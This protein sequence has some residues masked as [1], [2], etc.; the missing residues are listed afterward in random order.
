M[1]TAVKKSIS[2]PPDLAKEAEEIARAEGK[3]FSGVIQDALRLARRTR[4][5]RELE[6]LQGHWSR[7]A[8]EKGILR[9]EDLARY[10]LD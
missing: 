1:G 10:L 2:L 5:T 3:S 6:F 4:L 7:L 9:E 8:K